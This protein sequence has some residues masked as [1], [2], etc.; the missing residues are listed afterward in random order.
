MRARCNQGQDARSAVGPGRWGLVL[1][2]TLL[3]ITAL[4]VGC[5][6]GGGSGGGGE[7]EAEKAEFIEQAN[8]ACERERD[9]LDERIATFMERNRGSMPQPQLYARLAQFVLLPTVEAEIES[10]RTVGSPAVERQTVRDILKYEQLKIDK[11][12]N[13]PRVPSIG[14]IE[15]RFAPSAEALRDYGLTACAEGLNW[16][17][18]IA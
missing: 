10:V 6:S 14:A 18:D 2:V 3:V 16:D 17:D 7:A 1:P 13:V 15:R 9:G 4:A 11:L 8:A 5:G 12:A